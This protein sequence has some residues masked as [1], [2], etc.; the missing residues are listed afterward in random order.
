MKAVVKDGVGGVRLTQVPDASLAGVAPDGSRLD[1]HAALLEVRWA[2]LCGSDLHVIDDAA[3][4]GGTVLG[5]ELVGEVVEVGRGLGSVRV[6]DLCVVPFNVSCGSC[7]NCARGLTTHCERA[8][9]PRVGATYGMGMGWAGFQAELAVVPW[10]DRNLVAVGAGSPHAAVPGEMLLLATDVIPTALHAVRRAGVREAHRVY[11]AGAGPIGF[12]TALVARHAGATV[13]VGEPT[14]ARAALVRDAGIR[15]VDPSAG[16][17]A[18]QLADQG[19]EVIDAAV[20]CVG[21]NASSPERVARA[22][23]TLD[24]LLDLVRVGGAIAM[25]GAYPG[26]LPAVPVRIG[27]MWRKALTVV[28]GATPA[29][30][31]TEQAIELV[32]AGVLAPLAPVTYPLADAEAAHARFRSGRVAKVALQAGAPLSEPT[33]RSG[34]DH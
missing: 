15:V 11:V 10:A 25:P 29:R 17:L 27:T 13:V 7:P 22:G 3:V 28:A 8:F 14:P 1:E 21:V 19:L 20:D 26:H 2:G 34:R 24:A 9:P 18:T 6:G 32:A 33:A 5:H 31:Y 4:P 16:D 23:A 12:A 30:S